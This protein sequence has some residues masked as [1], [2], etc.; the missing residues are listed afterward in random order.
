LF[1]ASIGARTAKAQIAFTVD[2]CQQVTFINHT[3]CPAVLNFDVLPLG[4][5]GGLTLQPESARLED[6]PFSVVQISGI[7]SVNGQFVP[8][9]SPLAP[10]DGGGP[11]HGC[12]RFDWWIANVN[13]GFGCCFDV[14]IDPCNCTVTLN[15]AS[16]PA[17]CL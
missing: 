16:D 9:H 12:G 10:H 11:L 3:D 1:S 6:L 8:I 5:W 4:A 7:Y 2:R 13:I 17:P 14:C 15:Y